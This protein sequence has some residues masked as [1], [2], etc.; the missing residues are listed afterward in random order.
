MTRLAARDGSDLRVGRALV[1]S[2][3]W[4]AGAAA[5]VAFGAVLT[6][7]GGAGAPGLSGLDAGSDLVVTP[8][9]VGAAVVVGHLGWTLLLGLVRGR[10]PRESEAQDDERDERRG[11]HGVDGQVGAEVPPTQS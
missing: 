11:D 2:G 9:V 10:R 7:L 1:L 4:G 6:A 3:A 5:G 8:W